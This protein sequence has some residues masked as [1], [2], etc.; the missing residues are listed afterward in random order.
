M[1]Y[2]TNSNFKYCEKCKHKGTE[3]CKNCTSNIKRLNLMY[4][5]ER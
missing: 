5:E 3:V 4:R 1:E 2:K